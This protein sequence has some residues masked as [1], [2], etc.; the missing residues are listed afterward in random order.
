MRIPGLRCRSFRHNVALSPSP[1]YLYNDPM[2]ELVHVTFATVVPPGEPSNHSIF[3]PVSPSHAGLGFTLLISCGTRLSSL[4]NEHVG[5]PAEN[6]LSRWTP[7]RKGSLAT[8]SLT[9]KRS[10]EI[11]KIISRQRV[12]I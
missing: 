4:G 11:S 5:W 2:S 3:G 1:G 6:Y 8:D 12:S 7:A 9:I 10:I